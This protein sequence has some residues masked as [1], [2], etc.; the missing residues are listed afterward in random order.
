M[1]QSREG[2][3]TI[4]KG[5]LKKF[6]HDKILLF[7]SQRYFCLMDRQNIFGEFFFSESQDK[8]KEIYIHMRNILIQK[9]VSISNT[10]KK[11]CL[12]F[13]WSNQKQL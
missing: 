6:F 7:L 13:D 11:V 9:S 8:K 1:S 3:Q 2:K 5:G 10:S 12:L 4:L